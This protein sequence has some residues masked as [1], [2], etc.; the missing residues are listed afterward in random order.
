M[1][2][3]RDR[4][5]K[6]PLAR[7]ITRRIFDECV[8]RGLLTMAYAPSFR[9]Q[10]ALTIDRETAESGVAV[11]REVFDLLKRERAWERTE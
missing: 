9:L 1:E 4:Q 3:V 8:R 11:L 7:S 5:T 6:E 10:P 2:L